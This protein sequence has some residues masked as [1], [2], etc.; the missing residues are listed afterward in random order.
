MT[1]TE[2]ATP[3]PVAAKGV[4][5]HSSATPANVPSCSRTINAQIQPSAGA[6]DA[7]AVA[8]DLTLVGDKSDH[9]PALSRA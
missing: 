3:R 2:P 9:F 4:L 7:R 6:F 8:H 1:L 5:D